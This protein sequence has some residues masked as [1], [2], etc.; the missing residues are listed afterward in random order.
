MF[1]LL[2]QLLVFSLGRI[3]PEQAPINP[4]ANVSEGSRA[5]IAGLDAS[6]PKPGTELRLGQIL[7]GLY[8]YHKVEY[9]LSS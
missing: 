6:G 3:L 9:V 1:V 8:V 5:M 4:P 7:S 2:H